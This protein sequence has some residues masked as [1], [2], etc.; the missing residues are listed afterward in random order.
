MG[1]RVAGSDRP[2]GTYGVPADPALPALDA[3]ARDGVEPTLRRAGLPAP[4]EDV[5]MLR[6]HDGRRCTFAVRAAGRPLV[7]KA[8]RR[9]VSD[10]AR[11]FAA[12]ERHG[13]ASGRGPTAPPLVALDHELRLVVFAHLEGPR[14]RELIARGARVGE[15]AADWL[16][17][18]WRL[19]PETGAPYRAADFVARVARGAAVVAVADPALG[20]RAA[21]LVSELEL[22]RP[23]DAG[24]VLAHGSFSVNHVI[25][26]GDGAGVIDWDGYC[27]G[28]R[29]LDAG[30]FLGTLALASTRSPELA[31]PAVEAELAFRAG[32]APAVDAGALRWYEAGARI[33]NARH[34][35]LRRPA[36]WRERAALLL[37]G[38]GSLLRDPSLPAAS[39]SAGGP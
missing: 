18:Q 5:V 23:A 19:P 27:Q 2:E 33:R 20:A 17:R 7:A 15:L 39:A 30:A 12:L 6:Y 11:L 8:F 34:V 38:A 9:D 14:G 16:A 22:Q 4:F 25:D 1:T 3:M 29:E 37:S 32:I 35:C 31:A 10:Q 28:A 13:L 26:R 36:G 24:P 21:A